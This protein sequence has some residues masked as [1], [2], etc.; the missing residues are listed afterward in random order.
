MLEGNELSELN[1]LTI[2]IFTFI[3]IIIQLATVIICIHYYNKKRSTDGLLM[4][5]G[6]S[7][8]FIYAIANL[9]LIRYFASNGMEALVK[10]QAI[11]SLIITLSSLIFLIGFSMLLLKIS[12]KKLSS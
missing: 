7:I 4:M 12:T 2:I 3:G 1:D 8:S 5:I 10:G 9:F 6:S 11:A